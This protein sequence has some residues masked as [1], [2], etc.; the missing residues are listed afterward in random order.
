MDGGPVASTS[1][2]LRVGFSADQ[3]CNGFLYEILIRNIRLNSP[4]AKPFCSYGSN[5]PDEYTVQPMDEPSTFEFRLGYSEEVRNRNRACE[6]N[7][8]KL[9]EPQTLQEIKNALQICRH[10]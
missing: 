8:G 2:M 9:A 6:E 7:G 5:R 10:S 1:T 4:V 3:F